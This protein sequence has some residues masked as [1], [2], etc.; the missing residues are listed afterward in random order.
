METFVE[1]HYGYQIEHL[2]KVA[3]APDLLR[4]L[5]KCCDEEVAHKLDA[6]DKIV[7]EKSNCGPN[8]FLKAWGKLVANGSNLAVS[9][10]KRF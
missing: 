4:V 2:K 7:Q 10:A 1:R 3:D 9:L 5:T 8:F 6:A